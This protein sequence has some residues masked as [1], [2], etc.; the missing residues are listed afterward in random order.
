MQRIYIYH[1]AASRV[2]IP[3][4]LLCDCKLVFVTDFTEAFVSRQT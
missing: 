1:F 4:E 2:S 3:L